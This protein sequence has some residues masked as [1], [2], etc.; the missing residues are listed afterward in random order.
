MKIFSVEKIVF[1]TKVTHYHVKQ[2]IDQFPIYTDEDF[3]ELD[4]LIRELHHKKAKAGRFPSVVHCKGG[5]GR[6]G[7]FIALYYVFKKL[8]GKKIVYLFG[9]FW[10]F[11]NNSRCREVWR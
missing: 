1:V 2:W 6:S 3:F 11:F 10:M 5:I 9:F 8:K 7:T 4:K